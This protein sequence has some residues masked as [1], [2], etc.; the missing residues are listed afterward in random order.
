[1]PEQFPEGTVVN[2]GGESEADKMLRQL[3]DAARQA[4]IDGRVNDSEALA[5]INGNGNQLQTVD[6]HKNPDEPF[7]LILNVDQMQD[8]EWNANRVA[9]DKVEVEKA[10]HKGIFNA[11]KNTVWNNTYFLR[12]KYR[13][14]AMDKII[15][16]GNFLATEDLDDASLVDAKKTT[17]KRFE[18]DVDG[19]I[20]KDAGEKREALAADDALAIE[21][22]D[23]IRKYCEGEFGSG[24]DADKALAE[25]RTMMMEKF[26]KDPAYGADRLGEG[27]VS[28][29]NMIEIAKAVSG[30]VEHGKSMNNILKNMQVILGESRNNTRT[31]YK[32][33]F[34]DRAAEALH[35]RLPISEET[36]LVALSIAGGVIGAAPMLLRKG[37]N[38]VIPILGGA[39]VGG[40]I[41]GATE[42]HRLKLERKQVIESGALGGADGE[43]ERR[44]ELEATRYETKSASELAEELRRLSS[45]EEFAKGDEALQKVL[46]LL[47]EVEMRNRLSNEK[48]IPLI[49]YS[50]MA[51]LQGERMDLALARAEAKVAL[52]GNLDAV[53]RLSGAGRPAFEGERTLGEII[54]DGSGEILNA[55]ETDISEKNRAYRGLRNRRVAYAIVKGVAIGVGGGIV[56]QEVAATVSDHTTG[57]L[58]QLNGQHSVPVGGVEHHTFMGGLLNHE[59]AVH[60]AGGNIL[61]NPVPIT[62][63]VEMAVPVGYDIKPDLNTGTFSILD[64]KGAIIIDK[65][66]FD[67]NGG[68]LPQSSL[69]ML[70]AA[71]INVGGAG[72]N[73]INSGTSSQAVDALKMIH[74]HPKDFAEV[75]RGTWMDNNTGKIYDYNELGLHWTGTGVDA[76]GDY[77]MNI[78]NMTDVGSSHGAEHVNVV[79]MAKEGKMY[80]AISANEAT[81]GTP[82]MVPIDTEGNIT[83][84]KGSVAAQLFSTDAGGNATFKGRFG[85]VVHDLTNADT[86]PGVR[87]INIISTME[88]PGVDGFVDQVPIDKSVA[89]FDFSIDSPIAS[90]TDMPFIIP[91]APREDLGPE[92]QRKNEPTPPTL[93]PI[94]S[95]PVKKSDVLQVPGVQEV[96]QLPA[97]PERVMIPGVQEVPQLSAAPERVM[98]TG[99]ASQILPAIETQ[100]AITGYTSEPL[101]SNIEILDGDNRISDE[102]L[103]AMKLVENE[104]GTERLADST[105]QEVDQITADGYRAAYVVR[106]NIM[107]IINSEPNKTNKIN[108]LL[109]LM[110]SENSVDNDTYMKAYETAMSMND[111]HERTSNL[112]K[113]DNLYKKFRS[114]S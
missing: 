8:A 76:N 103:A 49:R 36:L 102:R 28:V 39:T 26:R 24:Q 3:Q 58:E 74:D 37:A 106:D 1:M 42:A 7:K 67:P 15:E 53:N 40:I 105:K 108:Y 54:S 80:Y 107:N 55:I 101:R 38:T 99:E 63:N 11:I 34:I 29:N 94:I 22:K 81:Q 70:N 83:I 87:D 13:K 88:G 62:G 61:Q 4:E 25:A 91:L 52:N 18:S 73:I 98:I 6:G 48:R 75:A 90:V 21:T 93:P 60:N 27:V 64:A 104:D 97:A 86:A 72:A 77:K 23:L 12:N 112:L 51:G 92:G 111:M 31:E 35:K 41:L 45:P 46:M 113:L 110:T 79:E 109:R 84:P 78:S 82:I 96:P 2:S 89:S 33:N 57:V 56:G 68:P 16:T 9:M 69:N 65:V 100:D 30:A 95:E 14:E 50:S 85:E 17:F 44:Q 19:L 5:V 43:T 20:E 10:K 114:R 71:H 66:P 32:N 59:T 47:T